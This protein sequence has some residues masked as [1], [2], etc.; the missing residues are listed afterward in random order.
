VVYYKIWRDPV[1]TSKLLLSCTLTRRLGLPLILHDSFNFVGVS[2][3]K[4]LHFTMLP[5]STTAQLEKGIEFVEHD[6]VPSPQKAGEINDSHKELS[7]AHK[8]YLLQRHGTLD[9]DPLPSASP[10]D[11]YNW[12]RWKVGCLPF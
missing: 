8:E 2:R 3:S 11:P 1:G 5:K 9:L 4:I 7:A 6:E 10:A 12:P